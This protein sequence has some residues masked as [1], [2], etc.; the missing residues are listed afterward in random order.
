MLTTADINGGTADNV[1][2]GGSTAAAGTFTTGTIATADINGG[3]IDGTT[4]GGSSAAAGS[5]TT[6]G[7]TGLISGIDLTL[8]DS[9]PIITL[10]DSDGTD[11]FS[12][13]RQVTGALKFESRNNTNHG[14]I[15]FETRNNSTTK[16][17]IKIGTNGD[18]NFYDDD[19]STI[20]AKWDASSSRL[21]LGTNSP[22]QALDVVGS[23]KTTT[24]VVFVDASATGTASANTLDAY[25]EGT[26]TPVVRDATTGGN[27]ATMQAATGHYTLIG[28]QCT[29]VA[30]FININP[31]AGSPSAPTAGNSIHIT[32]LPFAPADL[33]TGIRHI[34]S[35]ESTNITYQHTVQPRILENANYILISNSQSNG[36][37]ST[38]DFDAI[39]SSA[40]DIFLQITYTV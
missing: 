29:I 22:S 9:S 2:I 31:D 12:R 1:V 21:G 35:L 5:F 13:I 24:G 28:N 25:E 18:I 38:L 32:G 4:I 15:E 11:A 19:G 34:G 26:W 39:N 6:L 14:S 16:T 27:A 40:A 36:A 3:A 7:A 20:G 23:I 8:T 10:N 17:R 37:L 30:R 33:P